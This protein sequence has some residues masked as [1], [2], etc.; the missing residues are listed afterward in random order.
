M[1]LRSISSLAVRLGLLALLPAAPASAEL[2]VSQLVVELKPGASR[3]ADIEIYNDS[4]ERSFV[5][6]EPREIVDVGLDQEKA[7]FAPDPEQLGLLVTPRRLVIEPHQRRRLRIATIGPVPAR[8]RV[9]RVTIKPVS[10]NVTGEVSGLKLLIGYDLLVLV[11]PT[12]TKPMLDVVRTGKALKI[13]NRGNASV[14]LADGKQCDEAGN[15]CQKLPGKRL[16]AGASWQQSLPTSTT[17]QYHV[18][19]S[20]GWSTIKF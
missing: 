4:D 17:G 16:Y 9:Y 3:T 18:R 11:R 10:G 19:S 14:E 20:V 13:V 1:S 5:S 15:N 8:E 2:A 6:V 12:A 7:R